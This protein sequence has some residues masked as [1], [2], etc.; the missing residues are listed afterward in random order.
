MVILRAVFHFVVKHTVFHCFM[1]LINFNKINDY[2]TR[3]IAKV[4]YDTIRYGY[5]YGMDEMV[6]QSFMQVMLE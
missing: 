5:R 2:H 6:N 3:E 1:S 4:E